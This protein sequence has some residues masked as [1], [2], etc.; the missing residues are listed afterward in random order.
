MYLD[1]HDAGDDQLVIMRRLEEV[2]WPPGLGRWEVCVG[3]AQRAQPARRHLQYNAGEA[4]QCLCNTRRRCSI[5]DIQQL[6][7]VSS[8]T[9]WGRCMI[10]FEAGAR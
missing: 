7:L 10:H 4:S 8:L 3:D 1:A 5:Q 9:T 6:E 2:L